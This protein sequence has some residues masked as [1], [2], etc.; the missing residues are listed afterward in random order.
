MQNIETFDFQN[1][2]ALIR[3]DFNVPLNDAFEVTDTTR[4]NA[5]VATIKKVLA[6]GGSVILMSHLGMPKGQKQ[7]K[8]SLKHIVSAV[9]EKIGVPV[10][11]QIRG[12]IPKTIGEKYAGIA[13]ILIQF[14]HVTTFKSQDSV[15]SFRKDLLKTRNIFGFKG[16]FYNTGQHLKEIYGYGIPII[17]S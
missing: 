1:K 8:F 2:K 16:Q 5:A 4:I 3:V 6:G 7:D 9:S 13:D 10:L 11:F 14:Y 15:F 17:Q 12:R